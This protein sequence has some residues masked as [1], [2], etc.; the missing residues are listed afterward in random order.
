MKLF[1]YSIIFVVT[2]GSAI[3]TFGTGAAVKAQPTLEPSENE[4]PQEFTEAYLES[5]VQQAEAQ[6]LTEE[7]S[8][9]LCN[10]TLDQFQAGYTFEEFIQM[11]Q[12]AQESG[13]TPEGILNVSST[14]AAQLTPQMN[15]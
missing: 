10:C 2:L 9:F 12:E 5:C 13:E 15:Q 14:C 7:Q 6:G 11:N 3:A 8:N 4:Y 1:Q